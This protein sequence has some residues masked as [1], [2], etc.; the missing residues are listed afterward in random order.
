MAE[1]HCEFLRL[2]EQ[3]GPP[4][5]IG[6]LVVIQVCICVHIRLEFSETFVNIFDSQS[7]DPR[8]PGSSGLNWFRAKI[9]WRFLLSSMTCLSSFVD[10]NVIAVV[11]WQPD[12]TSAICE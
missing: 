11:T 8:G 7:E 4:L 12:A 2:R 9:L 5:R 10:R 6:A 3:G 1:R